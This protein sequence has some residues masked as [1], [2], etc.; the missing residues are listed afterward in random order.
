MLKFIIQLHFWLSNTDLKTVLWVKRLQPLNQK[1]ILAKTHFFLVPGMELPHGRAM[2]DMADQLSCP[3]GREFDQQ[4]F[5]KFKGPGVARGE[6]N[7]Q[8]SNWSIHNKLMA[9]VLY[10]VFLQY[11][12][13]HLQPHDP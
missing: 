3:R 4:R 13:F 7:I 1:K 11:N 8:V 5:Q 10:T 9:N 2:V 6:M 12:L